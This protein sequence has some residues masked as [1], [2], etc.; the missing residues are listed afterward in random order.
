M[1][2][3]L[4]TQTEYEDLLDRAGFSMQREID[5]AGGISILEAVPA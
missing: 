3:F 2:R 5:T 1:R 4:L